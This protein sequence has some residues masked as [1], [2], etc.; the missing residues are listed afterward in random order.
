MKNKQL[1]TGP[2][3]CK[4][5]PAGFDTLQQLTMHNIRMHTRAGKRGWRQAIAASSRSKALNTIATAKNKDQRRRNLSEG[6]RKSWVRRRKAAALELKSDYKP[7]MSLAEPERRDDLVFTTR[8]YRVN[9]C[10][11]CGCNIA[12]VEKAIA[13]EEE[14]PITKQPRV[15]NTRWHIA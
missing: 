6:M 10:P 1:R 8:Q 14:Q 11:N 9:L 12:K 7:G 5:C 4:K 15:G 3:K 13:K 2:H